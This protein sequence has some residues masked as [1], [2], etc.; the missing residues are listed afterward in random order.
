MKIRSQM[1]LFVVVIAIALIAPI[2]GVLVSN[3]I[4]Q[5]LRD[6]QLTASRA[7]IDVYRLA[8]T[9]NDLYAGEQT[10]DRLIGEW[11][12][13]IDR[14][15]RSVGDL[16]GHPAYPY[17][18][19]E[20]TLELERLVSLWDLS[21][22]RLERSRNDL[23]GV[24]DD[25]RVPAFRKRGLLLYL[26]WLRDEGGYNDIVLTV[27]ALITNLRSFGTSAQDLLVENLT[28]ATERT[29]LVVDRL[30]GLV[31]LIAIVFSAVS[32][33]GA[34]AFGLLFSRRLSRRV[35]SIED[36]MSRVADRDVSVRAEIP[37]HD[38]LAELG[39]F[40]NRTLDVFSDFLLS[41]QRAVEDAES[42]KDGL[43]TGSAQSA[44]SLHEI[45]RNIDSMTGEFSRLNEQIERAVSSIRDIDGR[46]RGL[47]SDIGS[48]SAAIA[49]SGTAVQ[50]I[51]TLIRQVTRLS[52]DRQEAADALVRVILDGGEKVHS[53]AQLID[54]VT[55]KIDGILEIIEII[56]AVA[57]QT[58]LLSMNAAIE[59]AHAGDAGRGF[60]V[61]AEEIRKLAESTGE[62]A[63][64]IDHLLKSITATMREARDASQIGADS[65]EQISSDVELFRSALQDISD[66]MRELSDGSSAIVQTTEQIGT[67]TRS[68][69][70]SAGEIAGHANRVVEA[71]EQAGSMSATITSGIK[72]I[73]LGAKEILTAIN[74][75][76]SLSD[77]NRERMQRLSAVVATFTTDG[78]E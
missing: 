71:M 64:Q 78:E 56:N 38:E 41:V 21:K 36:A 53:A 54:S 52:E 18:T 16:T 68:V 27:S 28:D 6:L 66:H 72:E 17:L 47:S 8:H 24:I 70:D 35:Q 39:G 50:T 15:D 20:I 58:N 77:E 11:I 62:N 59:S 23:Q 42:L 1:S 69:D 55:T 60:A 49:E 43:S 4:V 2:A 44:A 29:T 30:T 7:T 22:S 25:T 76:A 48:Q 45:S 10:Q 37:G 61:V 31:R 32:V 34:V 14:F 5:Q 67:I 19:E 63:T 51:N 73:D 65:F 40:L 3:E 75:I 26:E 74:D 46:I 57:E 13:S 12:E 33:L 9:T